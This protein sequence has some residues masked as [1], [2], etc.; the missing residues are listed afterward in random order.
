MSEREKLLKKISVAQFAAWELHIYL[1]THPFDR[2]AR[3][4]HDKYSKETAMLKKEFESNYGPLTAKNAEGTEWLS[5]PWPW[6][7]QGGCD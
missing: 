4:M 3:E 1:D 5:D 2:S 6:D 7:Y